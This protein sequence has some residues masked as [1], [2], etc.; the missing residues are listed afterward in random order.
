MD[1]IETECH[2]KSRL[3]V[4][5]ILKKWLDKEGVDVTWQMLLKILRDCE[6]N[7]LAEKIENKI[8]GF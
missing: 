2:G 4:I 3:I 7:D 1:N 6:L 8:K 5:K